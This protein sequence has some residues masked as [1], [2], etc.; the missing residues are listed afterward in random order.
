MDDIIYFLMNRA[1]V[2]KNYTTFYNNVLSKPLKP[3]YPKSKDLWLCF[4]VCL[5][6]CNPLWLTGFKAWTNYLSACLPVSLSVGLSVFLPPPRRNEMTQRGWQVKI[7][8]ETLFQSNFASWC[9]FAVEKTLKS[10]PWLC[11][12]VIRCPDTLDKKLKSNHLHNSLS[13]SPSFSLSTRPEM[14]QCGWEDVNI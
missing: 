6:W 2:V 5:P 8:L 4:S 9:D 3:D 1:I 14:T 10:N 7:H 11:L 13:P 12:F